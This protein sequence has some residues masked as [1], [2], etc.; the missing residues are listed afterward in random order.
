M[1]EPTSAGS[2]RNDV[3]VTACAKRCPRRDVGRSYE[4]ASWLGS[5]AEQVVGYPR[6]SE[7]WNASCC[8]A[9]G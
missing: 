9:R 5:S 2:N 3:W 1:S 6:I 7:F 4:R 8:M